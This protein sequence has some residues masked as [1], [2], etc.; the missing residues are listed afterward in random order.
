MEEYEDYLR[1]ERAGFRHH[2]LP[3][4]LL[5]SPEDEPPRTYPPWRGYYQVRNHLAMVLGQR[6]PGELL[7]F[8]VVQGKYLV[9]AL[10]V[11]ERPGERLLGAWHALCGVTGKTIDQG[12]WPAGTSKP[13]A[14]RARR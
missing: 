7:W 5:V 12:W 13:M 6:S 8:L 1:A 4:P 14:G 11:G 10:R 9:G 2:V 3:V